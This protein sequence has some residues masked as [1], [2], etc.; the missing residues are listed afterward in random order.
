MQLVE[1]LTWL[2]IDKIPHRHKNYLKPITREH[3][4]DG[5]RI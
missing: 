1:H 4:N 2:A 5:Q 3:M